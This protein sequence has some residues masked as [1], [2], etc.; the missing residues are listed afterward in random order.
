MEFNPYKFYWYQKKRGMH[1]EAIKVV[2][3]KIEANKPKNPWAYGNKV[4]SILNGNYNE[5]DHRIKHELVKKEFTGFNEG[6][7]ELIKGVG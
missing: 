3:E 1:E 5:R 4:M 7:K 2:L 6:V